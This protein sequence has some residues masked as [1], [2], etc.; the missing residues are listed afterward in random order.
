MSPSGRGA[1]ARRWAGNLL[2]LG[3]STLVALL[4]GEGI[5]RLAIDIEPFRY[6]ADAG[7]PHW[8]Q[9]HPTRRYALTPGYRGRLIATEFDTRVEINRLGLRGPAPRRVG[10]PLVFAAG[11]SFTFGVGAEADAAVPA[12]LAAHLAAAGRP[13]EVW[14]L[15]VPGYALQPSILHVE[16]LLEHRPAAVALFVYLGSRASGANDVSGAVV[17]ERWAHD[18]SSPRPEL[19]P[20][21]DR[22]IAETAA[23]A[24]TEPAARRVRP[25]DARRLLERRSALFNAAM[26]SLAPRLRAWRQ[27]RQAT[28]EAERRQM[29]DGWR[30]MDAWLARFKE[31][32]ASA[33]FEPI[34]IAVPELPDLLRSERAPIDRLAKLAAR[35]RLPF[36][37][38]FAALGL[39]DGGPSALYYP[40]DG[41][42]NANGYDRLALATTDAVAKALVRHAARV[43]SREEDAQ[44]P[45]R[46]SIDAAAAEAATSGV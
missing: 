37:D 33:R 14:N 8:N 13:I 45:S 43:G 34:L 22:A 40:L 25:R 38:G 46:R 9:D 35:H 31:R 42:L 32:A 17:F 26:L 27:S 7:S 23:A 36:V 2:L 3:G 20:T 21:G 4:L 18:A 6:L 5:A 10:G 15:G 39:A 30:L 44:Q 1:R 16:E 41:H 11:D 29:E 24:Q 28:G 19:G 12:R